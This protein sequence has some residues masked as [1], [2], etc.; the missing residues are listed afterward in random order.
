MDNVLPVSTLEALSGLPK[1][2]QEK[3]KQQLQQL[4]SAPFQL[5]ITKKDGHKWRGFRFTKEEAI[6]LFSEQITR[7]DVLSIEYYAK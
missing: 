7:T 5:L 3:V 6:Q 2:E 4:F 1:E